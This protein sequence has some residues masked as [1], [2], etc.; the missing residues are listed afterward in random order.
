MMDEG[1][2]KRA[3]ITGITGFVGSHLA[4]LLLQKGF[5]VRG[6][7]R[8]LAKGESLK[9]TL[10]EAGVVPVDRLE[11]MEADLGSDAGWPA[12]VD[13]VSVVH[14][15]A[16]PFPLEEP[17]DPDEIIQPALA[18]TRRVLQAANEAGVRRLVVT[19]S[20]ASIIYG[21]DQDHP[22]PFT[23]EDFSNLDSPKLSTYVRSKV[24]AEQEAWDL[25]EEHQ[26]AV[27]T[28]HPGLILGP[29]VDKNPGTSVAIIK[30][31]LR[32]KLPGCP[33]LHFPIVDVRD[34]AEM[35][36]LAGESEEA[37]GQRLACTGESV[38]FYDLAQI[39]KEAFPDYAKKLP[40]R[41]LPNWLVRFL[42]VFDSS[43][44]AVLPELGLEREVSSRKAKELLDWQA[45]P[46][47]ETVQE[48]AQSLIEEKLV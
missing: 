15:V 47:S 10:L 30:E 43:I 7:V 26:L 5:S 36:F 2:E 8:S 4:V 46:C 20:V 1:D 14:H 40:G 12:A 29:L 48:T 33:R 27:T 45:R 25:A 42:S 13:G 44:R 23:E 6:T 41:E 17:D 19:S 11:L 35:H 16:S 37:A 9:K 28:I 21:H 34:V 24:L 22:Q 32:G 3:L 38:W 31:M 18:G 39:L